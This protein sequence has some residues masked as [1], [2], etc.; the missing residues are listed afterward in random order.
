MNLTFDLTGKLAVVTGGGGGL[1]SGF[2]KTL[3]AAGAKVAVCD[4]RP[5]AAE[6]VASEIR[7]NGGCA[8]ALLAFR[9]LRKRGCKGFDFGDNTFVAYF[10]DGT[11]WTSRERGVKPL[12]DAIDGMRERFAGARCYDRVVG[13]AAA[14]LYARLGV[15]E[16]YARVISE[17]A[18][19]AL[20]DNGIECSFGDCVPYIINRRGD[21]MCPMEQTVLD[22]EDPEKAVTALKEKLRSMQN[23]R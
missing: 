21:G 23:G 13:R 9:L 15:T 8:A 20:D 10:A 19:K 18:R 6:K 17:P 12:V 16:V 22:I 3:A 5:D 11:E 1:C 2:S 4:L 7:A 14:L